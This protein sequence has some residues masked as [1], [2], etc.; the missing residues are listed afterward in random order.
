MRLDSLIE[1]YTFMKVFSTLLKIL[2]NVKSKIT[3]ILNS[4]EN[5]KRKVPNQMAYDK[6]HQTNGQQLSYS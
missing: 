5:S 6:T 4:E 2:P 1:Q 3:K